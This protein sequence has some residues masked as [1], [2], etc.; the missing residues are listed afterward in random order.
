MN[1]TELQKLVS[2]IAGFRSTPRRPHKFWVPYAWAVRVL[3]D[4]GMSIS[5]ACKK[6]LQSS[7]VGVTDEG[8]NCL[9]VVYYKIRHRDWPAGL[10]DV[11]VD[12]TESVDSNAADV[13]E[14]EQG[15]GEREFVEVDVPE[16]E[17]PVVPAIIDPTEE[18]DEGYVPDREDENFEV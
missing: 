2:G 4:N 14:R 9:R 16:K 5:G 13:T 3:V 8:V 10:G 1:I 15:I 18:A 11:E 7:D 6:V 12:I 17:Q